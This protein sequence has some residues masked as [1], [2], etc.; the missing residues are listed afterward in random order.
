MLKHAGEVG[1]AV[2]SLRSLF[3]ALLVLPA[4][5][6]TV[7]PV[8]DA[9]TL[10]DVHVSETRPIVSVC[11]RWLPPVAC[12][13]GVPLTVGRV[14]DGWLDLCSVTLVVLP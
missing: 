6:P 7:V 11:V 14:T 4:F 12:I 13:G 10:Y 8:A 9:C 2:T 3:L 1:R 5:L